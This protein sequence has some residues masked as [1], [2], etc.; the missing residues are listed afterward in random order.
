[1]KKEEKTRISR[2]RILQAAI[3][4]FGENSYETGSMNSI[5]ENNGLSKG[6]IYHNFKNKDDLY[7]CALKRCIDE[8][9]EHISKGEYD[10]SGIEKKVIGILSRRENFFKANPYYKK[11]FFYSIYEPPKNLEKEMRALRREYFKLI[12]ELLSPFHFRN[13]MD[14]DFVQEYL[15]LSTGMVICYTEENITKDMDILAIAEEHEKN[16]RLFMDSL[17]FGIAER[18]E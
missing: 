6:L 18:E 16:L 7:L 15:T 5:C 10:E 14:A 9:N 4:E 12:T 3:R 2:E 1:M 17:L 13:G 8:M 11:L